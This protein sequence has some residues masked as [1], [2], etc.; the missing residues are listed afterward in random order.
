M[1]FEFPTPD[2]IAELRTLWKQAFQD[3]DD[4]LDDFFSTGFSPDRCRCAIVNGQLAAALYWF[5]CHCDGRKIAYLYAVATAMAFRRQGLCHA[6]MA[7]THALLAEQGCAGVMLVPGTSALASLYGSMGYRYCTTIREF[8]CAAEPEPAALRLIDAEEYARL[9]RELLPPGA[10]LQEGAALPFLQTQAKLYA[11]P[12]LLLAARKEDQTL[13]GLELL[14]DAAMGPGILSALGAA[15]GRFRTPGEGRP[16]A[17]YRSFG[18]S[19][20]P[21]YFAFAFD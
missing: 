9:R 18:G 8:F 12:H 4:F 13:F 19:P 17:M 11:G 14:G 10:V 2:R 1:R 21:D 16:F 20:A 15:Q 5:D 6:L 3:T 7:D